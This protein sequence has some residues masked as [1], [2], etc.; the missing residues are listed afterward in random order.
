MPGIFSSLKTR[1]SNTVNL[2]FFPSDK[3]RF[4]R[5]VRRLRNLV[6]L[7]LLS[8]LLWFI[9]VR[10]RLDTSVRA[11]LLVLRPFWLVFLL[12]SGVLAYLSIRRLI[13]LMRIE[14]SYSLYPEIEENWNYIKQKMAELSVSP[15]DLPIILVLGHRPIDGV[16]FFD[17]LQLR[18][19]NIRLRNE[20]ESNFQADLT[21]SAIIIT[22]QNAS[23]LGAY[24]RRI[25]L[26]RAPFVRSVFNDPKPDNI[27]RTSNQLIGLSGESQRVQETENPNDEQSKSF[28]PETNAEE[29]ERSLVTQDEINQFSAKLKYL[30]EL[31]AADRYPYCPVN[32]VVL[33]VSKEVMESDQLIANAI[34][35]SRVDMESIRL[36]SG[37]DFPYAV[38]ASNMH[39]LQGFET[40]VGRLDINSKMRYLGIALHTRI[41]LSPDLWSKQIRKGLR[42]FRQRALPAMVAKELLKVPPSVLGPQTSQR[43]PV[44]Q[45]NHNAYIFLQEAGK[46]WKRLEY[47]CSRISQMQ[48]KKKSGNPRFAGLFLTGLENTEV[49]PWVFIHEFLKH[50]LTQQDSISWTPETLSDNRKRSRLARLIIGLVLVVIVLV[51]AGLIWI[52]MS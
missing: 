7:V 28:K 18:L 25:E 19:R 49:G 4:E 40:L 39:R 50:L 36:A 43:G 27:K 5:N 12:W 37:L 17:N 33:V 32:G 26:A 14:P 42:W 20:S 24:T 47:Y 46:Q 16:H 34:E 38:L 9:T 51:L 21:E 48:L 45:S 30:C 2:I 22:C 23:A 41:D 31:I 15:K 6:I 1:V 3:T 44:I 10:T 35:M 29:R 52:N 13:Y 8:V 11:P